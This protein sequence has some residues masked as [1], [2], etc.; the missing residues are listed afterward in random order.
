[1]I[2]MVQALN[3]RS[4]RHVKQS[5]D[6]FHVLVGPNA[7]GKTTFFDV[8][9]F[10]GDLVSEGLETTIHERTDNLKD[11]VWRREGDRFELAVELAIREEHRKLLQ[12]PAYD[13]CRY[14]VAIGIDPSTKEN[15]ILAERVLLGQ[16]R[17]EA[18]V[19]KT[20]FPEALPLPDSILG[21]HSVR[22]VTMVVR[23]SGENV[24]FLAETSEEASKLPFKLGP[25]KSALANLP[26]DESKFPVSTWLKRVL[27][28]G[29]E[30]LVLNSAL[31][32]KPSPPGQPKG[33]RPDGSN[34]PWVIEDLRERDPE[35]LAEWIAHL[36]TALP[37]LDEIRTVVRPED[38]HRYLVVRYR[39]GFEVP[40]WMVSDG[41]LRLLALTLPAYIPDLQGIYL[42]EEP[43]NG[44]HPRAVETMF[45][46]LSS[47]Y[48]AQVLMATH[49]PVILSLAEPK[50]VLCF[51]RT[52]EGATD[53]VRGSGHPALREWRGETNLG[54]LYAAGVLG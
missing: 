13:R 20:A 19:R 30:S 27:I 33:F 47:V 38:R 34:L 37:D 28:D 21:A 39:E 41:T 8:I 1:M 29:I 18:S 40:S 5:L 49:S 43:E 25:R 32:R 51:A 22:P 35:R 44:I 48:N 53:I 11:L 23:K 10:L 52:E 45:Q 17:E 3:F 36:R 31:M 6:Q 15:A 14:E 42:I 46:S 54:V 9:H 7:S 16:E 12:N 4:L 24:I 2:R 50:Q 26:E